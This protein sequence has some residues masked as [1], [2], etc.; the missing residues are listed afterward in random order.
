M[1]EN[2]PVEIQARDMDDD[3]TMQSEMPV[4][5]LVAFLLAREAERE[6]KA[7]AAKRFHP[8]PWRLDPEVETTMPEGR[9]VVDTAD[10]GVLVAN[11]DFAA[12]F[13]VSHDPAF[14]LAD[15]A[16][17]RQI[18]DLHKHEVQVF[19]QAPFDP[20]TGERRPDEYDVT[21]AVCGWASADPTSGCLTL[22]L[23]ALPYVHHPDYREEWR[24]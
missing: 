22:R 14:V 4:D 23:L 2:H 13:Y 5:D 10:E 9:W 1:S 15:V 12:Q 24:P 7:I 16:A 21:C 8:T 18:I 6:A 11:G 17:K 3:P 20:H 19:A